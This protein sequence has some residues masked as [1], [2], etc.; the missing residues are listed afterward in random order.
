MIFWLSSIPG[1]GDKPPWLFRHEDKVVHAS[2]WT[3]LGALCAAGGVA[4][5][6][7]R[8][9]AVFIAIAI[10]TSYGVIDEWHQSYTPRR[11]ASVG[12]L[13]ADAFGA[14]L[15]AIAVAR[16]YRRGRGDRQALPRP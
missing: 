10:A 14:C 8:R 16:V 4:R 2:V 3:V 6:W 12:D 11:D 13:V 7:P 15:G 5:G 1:S 9:T